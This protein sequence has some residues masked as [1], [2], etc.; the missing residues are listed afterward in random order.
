MAINLLN[1]QTFRLDPQK[2]AAFQSQINNAPDL[3]SLLDVCEFSENE[4]ATIYTLFGSKKALLTESDLEICKAAC[5]AILASEEFAPTMER[6]ARIF[7]DGAFNDAYFNTLRA[8]IEAATTAQE[9]ANLT[10][11]I[12]P[13]T[14]YDRL[15]VYP[16][17]FAPKEH[18]VKE[19]QQQRAT[20]PEEQAAFAIITREQ[21]R[22]KADYETKVA[23]NNKTQARLQNEAKAIEEAKASSKLHPESQAEAE[24]RIQAEAK[25]LSALND[26]VI[27]KANVEAR[28]KDN[29]ASLAKELS[30]LEKKRATRNATE[31]SAIAEANALALRIEKDIALGKIFDKKSGEVKSSFQTA[32]TQHITDQSSV[33]K[34]R[35]NKAFTA[36]KIE[37][38]SKTHPSNKAAAT[39]PEARLTGIV[40]KV[41]MPKEVS[42]PGGMLLNSYKAIDALSPKEAAALPIRSFAFHEQWKNKTPSP[43]FSA[44]IN[45]YAKTQVIE[46]SAIKESP[47]S[48]TTIAS[49][50]SHEPT[51]SQQ[52][53]PWGHNLRRVTPISDKSAQTPEQLNEARSRGDSTGSTASLDEVHSQATRRDSTASTLSTFKFSGAALSSTDNVTAPSSPTAKNNQGQGRKL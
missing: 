17:V 46:N 31:S 43:A 30:Q 8:K 19:M 29:S 45:D 34:E 10:A 53:S 33:I 22:A 49:S 20:L 40:Y 28:L 16:N 52:S 9:L 51:S 18:L 50:Q 5:S 3:N 6:S 21:A 47:G 32:I 25:Y 15:R 35:F 37:N 41:F 42:L 23:I 44:V 4:K 38:D 7:V 13:E 48:Q 2:V 12:D 24:A 11:D 36:I 39:T 26:L 27:A 14:V 1:P